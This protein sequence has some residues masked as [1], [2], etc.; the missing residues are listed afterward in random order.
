MKKILLMSLVFLLC[1]SMCSCDAALKS[2]KEKVTGEAEP[3]MPAD[4]IT[5]LENE[6][7]SYELYDGY[8]KVIKY[9]GETT[10]VVIPSEIDDKPV[11]V[12]G[13]LCFFDT[14]AKVTSVVIPDSVTTIE[15]SAFYYA[16]RLTAIKIPD[17][18]TS[19]G[20]RAFAWC[21][22]LE[23]VTFGKNIT[24]I[25]EFCF[26]HCSSLVSLNIPA[27]IKSIGLRAFSYCEKLQE[28][29][30]PA[31]V[32]SIGERAF[33]GCPALE[34][35]TVSNP[36]ATLGSDVFD[37]SPN[38]AV[39][40]SDNSTAKNYCIEYNLRWTTSKDIEAVALGTPDESS[41][42]TSDASAD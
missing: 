39:I 20:S 15:S 40:A 4:Y 6:Q 1:I 23:S 28:E 14:T 32:Q 29:V 7:F 5:T 24:D 25:P 36:S 42:D 27:Y 21:E 26:N 18:V 8:V 37:G 41:D 30:I 12:I 10:D 13:N 22:S 38:V 17:S 33:S 34:F 31:S 3:E 19:L 9:I 16:D 2:I 11:T 35:V